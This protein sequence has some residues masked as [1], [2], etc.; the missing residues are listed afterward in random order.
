MDVHNYVQI[1]VYSNA[2]RIRKSGDTFHTHTVKVGTH[3]IH[4]Q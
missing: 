1:T 4:I 3:F 2:K